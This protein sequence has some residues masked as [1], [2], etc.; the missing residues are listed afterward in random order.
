MT[1]DKK[2]KDGIE[3]FKKLKSTENQVEILKCKVQYLRL[4]GWL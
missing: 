2:K 1:I 4:T 3:Y